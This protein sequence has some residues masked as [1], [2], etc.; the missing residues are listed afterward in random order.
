MEMWN[1]LNFDWL[2]MII[3]DLKMWHDILGNPEVRKELQK[4]L[5][6]IKL[7][8]LPIL[9]IT[10]NGKINLMSSLVKK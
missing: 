5:G 3:E 1:N 8:T 4:K 10:V 2:R 9:Q 6:K 7:Q